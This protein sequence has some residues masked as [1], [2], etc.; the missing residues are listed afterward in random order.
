MITIQPDKDYKKCDLIKKDYGEDVFVLTAKDGEQYLGYGAVTFHSDAAEVLDVV[1]ASGME[2]LEHGIYKSVL[3]FIE[4]RGVYD[5]ICSSG[6]PN[7]MKRLGFE[8]NCSFSDRELNGKTL[9]YLSLEGY[10]DKHC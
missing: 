3:N 7:M 8:P 9:Y 4:R 5:C 1:T 2:S 6:T 10:F